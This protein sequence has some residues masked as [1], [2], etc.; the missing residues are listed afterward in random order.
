MAQ[1]KLVLCPQD[2]TE[3]DFNGRTI[4]ALGPLSFEA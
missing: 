2:T 3:M 1:E 4:E